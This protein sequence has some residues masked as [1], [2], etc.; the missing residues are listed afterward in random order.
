[1]AFS[2]GALLNWWQLAAALITL[3]PPFVIAM[4]LAPES[5]R[6]LYSKGRWEAGLALLLLVLG[7]QKADWPWSG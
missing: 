3:V 5:P 4:Y 2:L 6:W 7:R 1:M